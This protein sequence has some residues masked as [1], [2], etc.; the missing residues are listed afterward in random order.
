MAAAVVYSFPLL[1]AAE[2][3]T[4]LSELGIEFSEAALSKPEPEPVAKLFEELV[5]S[6]MGVTRCGAAQAAACVVAQP[7]LNGRPG[8]AFRRDEL[9]QPVFAALD[10]LT[11]P[12]LHEE[13]VGVIAFTRHLHRLVRTAGITDF[14]MRARLHAGRPGAAPRVPLLRGA[15]A[16]WRRAGRVRAGGEAAAALPVRGAQLC[17][18]QRRHGGAVA[19]AA[20]RLARRRRRGDGGEAS[21]RGEGALPGRCAAPVAPRAHEGCAHSRARICGPR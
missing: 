3:S 16:T 18:V 13:S 4:C 2:I 17:K 11:Y 20:R 21:A 10:A 15:D 7:A 9:Q 1:P 14:S 6:Q 19:R 8:R 5:V 12:E